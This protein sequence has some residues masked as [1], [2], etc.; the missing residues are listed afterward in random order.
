MPIAATSPR[1]PTAEQQM[2]EQEQTDRLPEGD[3]RTAEH[4]RD[5]RIPEQHKDESE[6]GRRHDNDYDSPRKIA[7][8]PRTHLVLPL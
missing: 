2:R 8:P 6:D 3:R 1:R 7:S 5:Q 4:N